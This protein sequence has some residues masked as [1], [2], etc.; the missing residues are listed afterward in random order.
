MRK[1]S[2][3]AFISSVVSLSAIAAGSL[4][5][6]APALAADFTNDNVFT[7]VGQNNPETDPAN[8]QEAV[9]AAFLSVGGTVSL[10]GVFDFGSC[11]LCVVVPGP[12]T[13]SGTGD[14]SVTDS[15]G[16]PTTV[17]KASGTAPLAILDTGG[18]LGNIT[19]ERIWFSG[20]QTL[21]VMLLQVRGTFTFSH[22]KVSGVIP[23]NEF[24]F[25]VAGAKVGAVTQADSE[26]VTAA[27]TRL[28]TTDG[29]KLTGAVVLDSNLIDH[30]IPMSVGDDNGFAFAQCHLKLIQVTNNFIRA[31]EAV[32]IEGCREIDAVYVIANNR[33]VQT[34]TPSNMAQLTNSP[35]LVR[36]GGH[37][38]AIKPLDSEAA[39]VI[40]RDNSI[41]MRQGPRT[42]VCVMTGNSNEASATRINGNTCTMDGQFAAILGGWAGT[43]GFFNPSYMQNAN[44]RENRFFGRGLFGVALLNFSF[45]TI[46]DMTL[47]NK[48]HDNVVYNNDVKLFRATRN[49]VDLGLLTRDNVVV[50]DFRGSIRDRGYHNT[51]DLRPY[52]RIGR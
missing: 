35:G 2:I 45:L 41:D 30:E 50:E 28:G 39:L 38:A 10:I 6:G 44:M 5:T 26:A 48:G 13:I 43:P 15:A 19:V 16:A 32:E 21:A 51:I 31:G 40:V 47:I 34:P 27:L 18:P 3:K 23:G 37:P 22:N 24:R 7:V 36:H 29:P 46:P 1:L 49:A 11:T 33:I 14:P 4:A 8:V 25:A 9:N 17:I 20:A 12:M 52:S 42:G